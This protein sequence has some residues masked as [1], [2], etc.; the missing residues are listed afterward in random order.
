[1]ILTD[2]KEG[3]P[4]SGEGIGE[5]LG[6]RTRAARSFRNSILEDRDTFDN[7]TQATWGEF[8]DVCK[9][10]VFWKDDIVFDTTSYE[11]PTFSA[12]GPSDPPTA[13]EDMTA[14]LYNVVYPWM[15]WAVSSEGPCNATG[16]GVA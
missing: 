6:E 11:P 1:M 2:A 5:T 9:G 15:D 16:T 3:D 12:E 14:Y 8:V 7:S 13:P 10:F 4:L